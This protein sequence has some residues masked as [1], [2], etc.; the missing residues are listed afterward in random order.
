[1][2]LT[3]EKT[4]MSEKNVSETS[5]PTPWLWAAVGVATALAA[6][7]TRRLVTLIGWEHTL[8]FARDFLPGAIAA[9][10][11]TLAAY[12]LILSLLLTRRGRKWGMA[13]AIAWGAIV[14][15]SA[16]WFWLGPQVKNLWYAIAFHFHLTKTLTRYG[17]VAGPGVHQAQWDAGLAIA[18]ALTSAKAFASSLRERLDLGILLASVFFGAFY[19]LAVGIVSRLVT[20]R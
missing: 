12:L 20:P 18:L 8:P 3:K 15:G 19:Y 7:E 13:L 4:S 11:M 6:I 10:A 1:M 17:V 14:A 16:L 9:A 2:N 5:R